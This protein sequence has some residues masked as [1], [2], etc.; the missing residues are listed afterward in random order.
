MKTSEQFSEFATAMVAAKKAFGPVVK[1]HKARIKSDKA[2]Y[3][4]SYADLAA[5]LEAC[6]EHLL[7]AGIFV[8]QE[9][10]AD[11]ARVTVSLRMVH[12]GSGQWIEYEPLTMTASNATPQQLGSAITYARRYQLVTAL[13]LAPQD[14]DGAAASAN[15]RPAYDDARRQRP[16]QT[17]RPPAQTAAPAA[18]APAE[19]QEK[20]KAWLRKAGCDTQA[21]ANLVLQWA[22]GSVFGD[23]IPC[24][25][26]VDP[27]LAQAT[28]E[29]LRELH[30]QGVT[31]SQWLTK[32]TAAKEADAALAADGF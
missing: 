24:Q 29:R 28:L 23:A 13:G 20:I 7:N 16:Q 11:G 6:E 17:Q 26:I 1:D 8:A 25:A 10:V 22:T 31:D 27:T 21:K 9:S 2:S 5:V 30:R 4:Y 32:A 12:A 14:D 15:D 18:D 3:D 19:L